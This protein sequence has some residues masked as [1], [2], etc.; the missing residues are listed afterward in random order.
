MEFGIS[1]V[2]LIYLLMLFIPN[3]MW[4]IARPADYDYLAKGENRILLS[5]SASGKYLSDVWH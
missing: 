5:W 2:G 4:S 3:I 1:Y